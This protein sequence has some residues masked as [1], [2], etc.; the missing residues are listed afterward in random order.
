MWIEQ[1][2][3]TYSP[4][5]SCLLNSFATC[6]SKLGPSDSILCQLENHYYDFS[7][8]HDDLSFALITIAMECTHLFTHLGKIFRPQKELCNRHLAK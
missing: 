4:S 3:M 1:A 8:G 2:I 7:T 6:Q 5:N